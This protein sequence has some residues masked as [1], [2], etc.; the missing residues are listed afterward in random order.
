MQRTA[1]LTIKDAPG[2]QNTVHSMR[3]LRHLSIE[4]SSFDVSQKE[5]S[6]AWKFGIVRTGEDGF[7]NGTG[8]MGLLC[9]ST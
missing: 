9:V 6:Q 2:F 5:K 1:E 7:D 4:I 8:L 3:R